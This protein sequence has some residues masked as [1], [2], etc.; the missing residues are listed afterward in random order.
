MIGSNW[1]TLSHI[2][3]IGSVIHSGVNDEDCYVGSSEKYHF[4]W[5][6]TRVHIS[7]GSGRE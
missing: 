2:G 1:N 3:G 5:I 6:L 7:G 4:E